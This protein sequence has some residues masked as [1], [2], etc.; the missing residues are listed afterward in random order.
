VLRDRT[1]TSP[2]CTAVK[3]CW[4]DSGWKRTFVA[5]PNIAAAIARQM[6]TSMPRQ[7]PWASGIE[8]PGTPGLTPQI[9]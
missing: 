3:R 5:S 1:S 8:N 2:D 4:I 6:S 7:F 9:T